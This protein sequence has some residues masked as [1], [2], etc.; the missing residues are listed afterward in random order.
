M[1]DTYCCYLNLEVFCHQKMHREKAMHAT[2]FT[3]LHINTEEQGVIKRL[4]LKTWNA[5]I[6]LKKTE[7][8]NILYSFYKSKC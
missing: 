2:W 8:E 7:Y 3:F 6:H 4:I 5:T 1:C